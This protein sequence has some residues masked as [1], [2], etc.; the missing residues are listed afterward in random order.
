MTSP[1]QMEAALLGAPVVLTRSQ[2]TGQVG[3]ADADAHAIWSALG[4]PE[5]PPGEVAF[6]QRDVVALRT[7]MELRAAGVIQPDTLLVLARAMGQGLSRLAEA[8]I[9][10]LRGEAAGLS[11]EE[12]MAATTL[13]AAEVLPKVESLVVHVWRRQFAAA[14]S[15]SFAARASDGLP[16][17]AVGFVDLVGW[18][19][20]S[21]ERDAHELEQMLEK[22]EADTAL[23]V[24]A[25][26]GRVVKTIGDEIMF[27]A[28]SIEAAAEVALATVEA[29]AA[30]DQLPEVRAGV[31]LGQMITRLGD[32]FGEPVNLA[33][34]LTS[35]ARPGSVLV[36]RL[37]AEA[38]ESSTLFSVHRLKHRS[39]RGYAALRPA[40]LR[41]AEAR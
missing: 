7:V 26:G 8:Q 39:V 27:V 17:L 13:T 5:V 24:T 3:I 36:D 18:T 21:R 23:R 1:E 29:H 4:F 20:T 16:V 33:S 14:T 32:V 9:D 19:R 10:V 37:A 22:F 15:R 40:V 31:A 25:A 34:R 11:V 30:D 12:A 6:T 2:V 28:D 38:L 35:E 41:R